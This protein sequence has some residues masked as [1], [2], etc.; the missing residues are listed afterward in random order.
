M[1]K[2]KVVPEDI[3][4]HSVAGKHN[5]LKQCQGNSHTTPS[6]DTVEKKSLQD[7]TVKR[8]ISW[9]K[10]NNE[11]WSTLDSAVQS[12]LHPCNSLSVR[13]KLLE[14]TI[15]SEASKMFGHCTIF[16]K[17]NLAG[18]TRHTLQSIHLIKQENLLL[19]HISS[20]VDPQEQVSLIELLAPIKDKIRNFHR[21]EKRRKKR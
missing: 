4:I 20:T 6:C 16:P 7:L 21:A 5:M 12:Q 17:R 1:R 10:M 19:T 3:S 14:D 2:C 11:R 13:V 18:K 15:Y 9:G 8:P